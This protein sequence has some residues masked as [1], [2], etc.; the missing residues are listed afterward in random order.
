MDDGIVPSPILVVV[1]CPVGVVAAA[2]CG[3]VGGCTDWACQGLG[4]ATLG[5]VLGVVPIA[6]SDFLPVGF[7][8]PVFGSSTRSNVRKSGIFTLLIQ[9]FK[10]LFEPEAN[11]SNDAHASAAAPAANRNSAKFIP[12]DRRR[13]WVGSAAGSA[14]ILG[15]LGNRDNEAAVDSASTRLIPPFVSDW[16]W[17]LVPPWVVGVVTLVAAYSSKT[18]ARSNNWMA[19]KTCTSPDSGVASAPKWSWWSSERSP[20]VR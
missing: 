15:K 2:V 3:V 6:L 9:S 4:R 18:V 12:R 20:P 8:P 5:A 17:T 13:Y 14:G 7:A 11:G 16:A 19:D 1:G 10:K